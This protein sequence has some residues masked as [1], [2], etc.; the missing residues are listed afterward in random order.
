MPLSVMLLVLVGALLHATWNGLVKSGEDRL[1]ETIGVVAG[2]A[3]LTLCCLPFLPLPDR[4][5]WPYLGVSAFLHQGY[6]S[7]IALSYRKGDMSLVYPITRGTAPA[8]TAL[9]STLVLAERPSAGGW[10]GVLLVSGGVLLLGFDMRRKARVE[11]TPAL[12][13]LAN[14]GMVVLYTLVDGLG[15]RLSGHAFS[16]T[17]WGFLL[18][19][20]L[21]LP[22]AMRMRKRDAVPHLRE[23]WRRSLLGGSCSV[24]SYG[25]ALW[26]M[27]RAPIASVAA[28][29]ETSILFGVLI[30]AVM[31]NERLTRLRWA[32]VCL[33][34]AGAVTIKLW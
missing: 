31:L 20:L 3:A 18:G 7:L 4:A 16:Y 5:C 8:I 33:V 14:A 13:A 32:A 1:L 27:T 25:L 11:I 28:L 10:G 30:A 24:A 17:A 21:F 23:N 34:I 26:A 22:V 15:V 19:A 9:M 29:R 2:A 6:Y 12:Y